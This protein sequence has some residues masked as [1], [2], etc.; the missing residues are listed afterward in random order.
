[1][2]KNQGLLIGIVL[3]LVIASCHK[4]KNGPIQF[5]GIVFDVESGEP[6]PGVFTTISL[7]NSDINNRQSMHDSTRTDSF[8]AYHFSFNE[9]QFTNYS[10]HAS[11]DRYVRQGYDR[12]R[13]GQAIFFYNSNI[14]PNMVNCDTIPMGRET[15][16]KIHLNIIDQSAA[17]TIFCDE[18]PDKSDTGLIV[19]HHPVMHYVEPWDTVSVLLER[20]LYHNNHIVPISWVREDFPDDTTRIEVDMT[21]FDT[22]YLT[23]DL[24]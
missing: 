24:Q 6:M 23:L 19:S 7:I 2:K 22:S 12:R 11:K 18:I 10:T 8:G 20:Y 5:S 9:N 4:Q 14:D 3:L 17:Y 16:L 1:M 21:P 15:M 13:D